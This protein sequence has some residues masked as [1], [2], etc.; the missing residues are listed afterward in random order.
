MSISKLLPP[1]RWPRRK[2]EWLPAGFRTIRA[3]QSGRIYEC[4]CLRCIHC[5]AEQYVD[6]SGQA[7]YRFKQVY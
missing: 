5:D 4:E 1:C 2:H 7:H 3:P 6:R